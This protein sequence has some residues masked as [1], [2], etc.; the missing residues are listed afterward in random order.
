MKIRFE[1]KGESKQR[2][3]QAFLQKSTDERFLR[4]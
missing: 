4:F 3:L 1:T 2:R